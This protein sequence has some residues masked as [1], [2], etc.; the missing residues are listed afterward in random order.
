MLVVG[1]LS[2]EIWEGFK[3]SWLIPVDEKGV[4]PAGSHEKGVP[5]T[6]TVTTKT[7]APSRSNRSPGDQAMVHEGLW[8]RMETAVCSCVTLW[9]CEGSG[10]DSG[11]SRAPG[12]LSAGEQQLYVFL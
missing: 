1:I 4:P 5:G 10:V 11:S 8:E 9:P 12:W 6:G 3:D 7:L 2:Q